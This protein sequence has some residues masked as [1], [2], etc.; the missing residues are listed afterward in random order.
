MYCK[1]RK[2]ISVGRG[3]HKTMHQKLLPRG[4]GGDE[5]S[6]SRPS[7]TTNTAYLLE[8]LLAAL[9]LLFSQMRKLIEGLT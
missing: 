1:R 7:G 5:R 8:L 4:G 3:G 9:R 2:G 6:L